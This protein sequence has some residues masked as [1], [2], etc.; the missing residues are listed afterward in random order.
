MWK[1]LQT[2]TDYKGKTSHITD[3]DVKLNTL[4]ARFEENTMPLTRPAPKDCGLS[5]SVS[6][7]SKTFKCVNHHK[8][9]DPDGIPSHV[10]RA[11]ADQLAGVFT[12]IFNLSQSQSVVPTSRFLLYPRNRR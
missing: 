1:G 11:C 6:D 4:F 12:D 3:T 10:L 8:A 7:V 9:A 2:V 5:F